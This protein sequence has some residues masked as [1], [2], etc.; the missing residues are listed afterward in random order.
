MYWR[1]G[2]GDSFLFWGWHRHCVALGAIGRRMLFGRQDE[3]RI[4]LASDVTGQVRLATLINRVMVQSWGQ[5]AMMAPLDWHQASLAT[6]PISQRIPDQADRRKRL[7]QRLC[8]RSE[9]QLATP[10]EGNEHWHSATIRSVM[11]W[12]K[13][14]HQEA[15][16]HACF[17]PQADG[18]KYGTGQGHESRLSYRCREQCYDQAR[19]NWVTHECIRSCVNH[20][21]F[22]LSRDRARPETPKMD[23]SEPAQQETR[24]YHGCESI[25]ADIANFPHSLCS[26]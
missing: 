4:R 11:V 24:Q 7:V 19:I 12:T 10:E 3:F 13:L 17:Q 26:N 16:F 1:S 5:G 8:A 21:M 9:H 2:R 15:F 25:G 18:Y 6:L 20:P 23:S 22:L 14:D